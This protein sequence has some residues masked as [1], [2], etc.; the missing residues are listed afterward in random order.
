MKALV[1]AI[2]LLSFLAAATV[3]AVA[4]AQDAPASTPAKKHTK[5]HS[6]KA[7]TSKKTSKKKKSS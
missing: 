4:V 2:A 6:T 7:S 5:H 1:S 3:P